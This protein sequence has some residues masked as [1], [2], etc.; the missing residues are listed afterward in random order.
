MF[1]RRFKNARERVPALRMVFSNAAGS[2]A[3]LTRLK[4]EKPRGHLQLVRTIQK[5]APPPFF[6]A[7]AEPWSFRV[8]EQFN[9]TARRWSKEF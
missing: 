8:P 9:F 2:Q 1:A 6:G 7:L 4:L 5:K 3:A